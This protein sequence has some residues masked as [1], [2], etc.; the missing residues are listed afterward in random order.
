MFQDC[1]LSLLPA[2]GYIWVCGVSSTHVMSS[3]TDAMFGRATETC[4]QK[5]LLLFKAPAGYKLPSQHAGSIRDALRN[6]ARQRIA[7]AAC[8][9]LLCTH[10]V[11]NRVISTGHACCGTTSIQ[12]ALA[13]HTPGQI[14]ASDATIKVTKV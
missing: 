2:S 7:L 9:D 4:E 11:A 13:Q 6:P 3:N 12:W 5:P 1:H 10:N 14:S 8:Y